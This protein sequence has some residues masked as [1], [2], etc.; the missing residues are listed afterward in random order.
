MSS[1]LSTAKRIFIAGAG[2]I[3]LGLGVALQRGGHTVTG[4]WSRSAARR[5]R[6]A[7][8][9]AAPTAPSLRDAFTAPADILVLSVADAALPDVVRELSGHPGLTADLVVLHTSGA[10]GSEA[11]APLSPAARGGMHPLLSAPDHERA[12]ELLVGANFAVE[13]EPRAVARARELVAS[14]AGRAFA[15]T[16][17]GKAAYHAAAVMASNLVVSLLA[18]AQATGERAGLERGEELWPALAAGALEN[19]RR[20]GP[21]AALT[22]PIVRGDVET[23]RRHLE[24][25]EGEALQTYRTLSR[26]ALRLARER[27]LAAELAD[28]IEA[29]LA[30]P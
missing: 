11:L 2:A 7:H 27:G 24:A 8:L 15:V 25:L 21:R 26:T 3:G 20:L 1:A 23:V 17:E 18:T 6:A 28:A 5:E 13:G 29:L 12:A 22:G 30:A 14:L 16:S 9:L 19:V 10:I 4:A